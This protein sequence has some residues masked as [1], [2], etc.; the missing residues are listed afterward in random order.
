MPA[1]SPCRRP[2]PLNTTHL[3]AASPRHNALCSRLPRV[4]L[5]RASLLR[6]RLHTNTHLPRTHRRLAKSRS[7]R[8]CLRPSRAATPPKPSRQRKRSVLVER[9]RLVRPRTPDS[10]HRAVVAGTSA[11]REGDTSGIRRV[12]RDGHAHPLSLVLASSKGPVP[13]LANADIVADADPSYRRRSRTSPRVFVKQGHRAHGWSL[14][15]RTLSCPGGT[16]LG[17]SSGRCLCRSR[18]VVPTPNECVPV[19]DAAEPQTVLSSHFH[20]THPSH[21]RRRES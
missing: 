20:R 13:P 8:R 7:S 15:A 4:V 1:S 16:C 12:S 6:R 19:K 3:Y 9:G 21:H 14:S 18:E 5:G 11:V 17:L 2:C 10:T